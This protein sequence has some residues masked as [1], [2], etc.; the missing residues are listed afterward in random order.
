MIRKLTQVSIAGAL[1]V[2]VSSCSL[3]APGPTAPAATAPPAALTKV[4]ASYSNI[5]PTILPMWVAKEA[6]LFEKHGLD[7]DLQYIASATSVPAV[8]SGQMQIAT[9]GLSEVLGAI[10]GGADLVIV[11]TE[12]PGYPYVMEVAP[13][14]NSPADLKGKPVGISRIGSSSDIATRVVLKKFGLDADKD[15]TL[16]QTG[17]VSDRAA[18][19]QSGAIQAGVAGPPDTFVIE[20]AGWHPLFDLAAL[21]LPAVTLG[22]VVQRGYRDSNRAVVQA[23]VDALV[24]GIARVRSDRATS[25]EALRKNMKLEDDGDLNAAYDYF[26]R[27]ELMPFLPYPKLEQFADTVAI[28]GQKNE[29]LAKLDVPKYLDTSFVKSA[30]DRGLAGK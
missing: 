29:Q 12:V 7:V 10:A 22:E 4:V 8:I 2:T 24:E 11:T 13:G 26:A 21:G 5:A 1:I 14:I 6:G 9:V 28:L 19:M 20:R 3:T 17:S 23:Y 15:V 30:E 25:V 16:V 27:Q 18:A